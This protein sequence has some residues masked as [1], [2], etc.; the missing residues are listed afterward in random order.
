MPVSEQQFDRL[1]E[2]AT[3]N[4]EDMKEVKSR[5]TRGEERFDRLEERFDRLLGITI[6]LQEDMKDV[7]FRVSHLEH[8]NNTVLTKIDDFLAL[9]LHHDVEIVAGR[10]RTDRLTERVDLLEAR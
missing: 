7:K 8:S 4:Q 3:A 10:S 1:L 9:Y 2:L 6:T 5:L